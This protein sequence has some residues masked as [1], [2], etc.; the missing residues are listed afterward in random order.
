[1]HGTIGFRKSLSS[2]INDLISALL[3]FL[4]FSVMVR[5]GWRLFTSNHLP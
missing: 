2:A 1:M 3:S 5:F 4:C